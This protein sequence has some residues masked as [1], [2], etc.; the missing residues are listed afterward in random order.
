MY[1]IY[2][3]AYVYRYIYVC[4]RALLLRIVMI[5][6]VV[7]AFCQ[8]SANWLIK[9]TCEHFVAIVVALAAAAAVDSP[10]APNIATLLRLH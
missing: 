2:I 9:F 7:F 4:M 5:I 10:S 8:L 3:N 1:C 6:T